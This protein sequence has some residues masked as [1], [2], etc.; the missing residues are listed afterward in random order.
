MCMCTQYQS[1]TCNHQWLSLAEPCG[2]GM[3][4]MSCSNR[5]TYREIYAPGM[6]CPLCNGSLL[7]PYAT[8]MITAAACSVGGPPPPLGLRTGQMIAAPPYGLGGPSCSCDYREAYCGCERSRRRSRKE[9]YRR[10]SYREGD[11][12]KCTVM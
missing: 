6:C 12:G 3:N 7:D 4:L 11:G 10:Y 8:Q 5:N 9:Y 1:P 2:Y